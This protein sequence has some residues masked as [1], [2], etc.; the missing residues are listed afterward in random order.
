MG[1]DTAVEGHE[2]HQERWELLE[3][4]NAITDKPLIALAFVWVLL[5]V[6]DF[7]V[8]LN[9]L[10]QFISYVIWA[11]FALDFVIEF[12]IAPDKR[13]YLRRNWL[14]AVSLVLP[15]FRIVRIFRALRALQ[16]VRAARTVSLLRVVTSVNRGMRATA[17]T[18]GK[19]SIGYVVALTLLI[20]FV[21]AAGMA[22]FESPAALREAG[23]TDAAAAGAGFQSYGEA[24]W[25]T[26]M[27]LTTI[28]SAYWPLT[29]EGRILCWLLSI[30]ALAVF[31]YITAAVASYFVGQD[32]QN[33]QANEQAA[34]P[35]ADLRQE[36]A[37]MRQQIAALT[38]TLGDR[39]RED[40]R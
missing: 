25:W 34:A 40:G 2:L 38:A 32:Q 5:L 23:H 36:I 3:H 21:G 37:A 17:T 1:Q 35:G 8:G 16:A 29:I 9:P 10:L 13:R 26:A 27:I 28:G 4:I 11:L 39:P 30:Y 7:T 18:L 33:R 20:L 22:A 12:I 15:A 19:R 14:T 31:G 24:V 6:L